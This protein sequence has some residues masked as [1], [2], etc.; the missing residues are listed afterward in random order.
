VREAA[1]IC[2]RPAPCKLTF[3]L[4]TL[5]VL[6]ESRVTRATSVPILVFLDLSVLDLGP[7]Y[8]TDRSQT[9]RQTSDVHRRLMPPPYGGGG[10]MM[11]GDLSSTAE[12]LAF[13]IISVNVYA[14][15]KP[16]ASLCCHSEVY[17]FDH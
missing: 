2:T 1:T 10:I 14:E 15:F 11:T 4:L 8:A 13:T 5:K 6:S 9:E 7:M 3:D 16:N 12:P 17:R